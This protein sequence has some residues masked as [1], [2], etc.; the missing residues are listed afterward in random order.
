MLYKQNNSIFYPI[1][2]NYIKSSLYE[3]DREMDCACRIGLFKVC[4]VLDRQ[5]RSF[6][7]QIT[8]CLIGKKSYYLFLKLINSY[9]CEEVSP[10]C[11]ETQSSFDVNMCVHKMLCLYQHVTP[12][13]HKFVFLLTLCVI[14]SMSLP[15]FR[16]LWS[17]MP[18][19]SDSDVHS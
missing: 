6:L 10:I 2:L 3:E 7:Q 13:E 5:T 9:L 17:G 16:H 1:Y 4:D 11:S 14:S 12:A 15:L 18:K 19:S 8:Q